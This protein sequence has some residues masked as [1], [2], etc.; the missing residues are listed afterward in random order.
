M[1][2][3]IEF[4]HRREI[5]WH[6]VVRSVVWVDPA[7]TNTDSSDSQGI[8]CDALLNDGTIL[9]LHSWE[10][11]TSPLE[12]I[13]QAIRIAWQYR[14][15]AVGIETDQGGDTWES[16]YREAYRALELE[17]AQAGD[18]LPPLPTY[19]YAKAGAGHGPKAHRSQQ[20]LAD[21]ERDLVAHLDG[22]STVLERALRRFPRTKPYDLVDAAYWSWFDLRSE[23]PAEG[24]M[25]FYDP[26][27]ISP[28]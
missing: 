12:A 13:K 9:R 10:Q 11:R 18:Q 8:Q 3:H 16:V 24:A 26:V 4:A 5:P 6:E 19:R 25:E 27:R 23:A 17:Y 7:V 15:E 20:M 21:Y 2:N 22:T 28:Y 14:A 1:W